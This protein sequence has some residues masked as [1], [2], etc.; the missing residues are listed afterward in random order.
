MLNKQ[1]LEVDLLLE[2]E[3]TASVMFDIRIVILLCKFALFNLYTERFLFA[4]F[5]LVI[6]RVQ[7]RLD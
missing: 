3:G 7:V 6:I 1:R 2:P 5:S 4:V